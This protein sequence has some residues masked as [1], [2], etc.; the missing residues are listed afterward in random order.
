MTE[1]SEADGKD[2]Q[3]N[4]TLGLYVVSDTTVLTLVA[5]PVRLHVRIHTGLCYHVF[6]KLNF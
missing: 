1:L 2:D 4:E 3:E 6:C 5:M